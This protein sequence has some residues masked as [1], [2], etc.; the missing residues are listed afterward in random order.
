MIF[1]LEKIRKI[2]KSLGKKEETI[3]DLIIFNKFKKN[4]ENYKIDFKRFNP[5]LDTKNRIKIVAVIS[6]FLIKIKFII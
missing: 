3:N 6:F 2:C 1:L 5:K 4:T